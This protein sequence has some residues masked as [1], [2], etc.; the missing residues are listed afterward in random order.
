MAFTRKRNGARVRSAAVE[1][2]GSAASASEPDSSPS[3]TNLPVVPLTGHEP[4]LLSLLHIAT[5][6]GREAVPHA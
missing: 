3:L 6:R 1:G 4:G 5:G 2:F